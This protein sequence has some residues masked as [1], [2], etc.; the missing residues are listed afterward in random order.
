MER[1]K[2]MLETN[3]RRSTPVIQSAPKPMIQRDRT[4]AKA[5]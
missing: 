5:D 3:E 4:E 2:H 1:H